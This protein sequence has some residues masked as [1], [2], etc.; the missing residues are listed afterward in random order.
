MI[1][2]LELS[3]EVEAQL[4]VGIAT[5]DTESIRQ[6]LVQAFSPTIEKLL[7]QDTD[8]LDYQA[9]ESIAD[10]LADELIGGIEPNMPLLSDYAVS[11]ASIYEDHP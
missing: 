2:T 8:Q 1:I 4:R 5:H 3:P 9:F 6:L 7:Q 10:Q 11:R